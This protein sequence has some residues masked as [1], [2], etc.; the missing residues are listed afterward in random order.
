MVNQ[1]KISKFVKE[2]KKKKKQ[3]KRKKEMENLN[4][5]VI[6]YESF[7]DEVLEWIPENKVSNSY[8]DKNTELVYSLMYEYYKIYKRTV[9]LNISPVFYA[10][11]LE[12]TLT[13]IMNN[14]ICNDKKQYV[15]DAYDI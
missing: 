12:T 3:T 15:N 5:D 7:I 9:H 2:I 1:I 13:T 11:I 10:N 6:S 14:D 4:D 8:L